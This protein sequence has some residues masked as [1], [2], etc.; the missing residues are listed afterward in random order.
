MSEESISKKTLRKNKSLS[1]PPPPPPPKK[2]RENESTWNGR[3]DIERRLAKEVVFLRPLTL[4][5]PTPLHHPLSFF[6]FVPDFRSD[7]WQRQSGLVGKCCRNSASAIPPIPTA[8]GY[9]KGFF[10]LFFSFWNVSVLYVTC[11]HGSG[12]ATRLGGA[13]GMV[14][15]P[16]VSVA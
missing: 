1:P 16:P 2:N 14:A 15:C 4:V 13:C 3:N 8:P 11:C 5:L 6:C 9:N 7:R 10:F 12:V